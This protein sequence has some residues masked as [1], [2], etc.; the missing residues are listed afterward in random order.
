V[1]KVLLAHKVLPVLMVKMAL[2]QKAVV[3]LSPPPLA[4]WLSLLA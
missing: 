1:L 3:V 2:T 4:S